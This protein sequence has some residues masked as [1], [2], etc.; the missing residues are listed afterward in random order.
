VLVLGV[1]AA[2][3]L[4]LLADDE[5]EN[6]SLYEMQISKGYVRQLRQF[7]GKASVL[8]DELD[9]W[10]A[11]LWHGTSLAL[12]VLWLSVCAAAVLFLVA[13]FLEKR[14]LG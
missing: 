11:S 8:F 2:G 10:F 4:Y 14:D 13:R 7:G 9:R 12:T 3:A 1:C 6:A 5:G